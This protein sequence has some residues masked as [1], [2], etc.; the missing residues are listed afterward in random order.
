[1]KTLEFFAFDIAV[2]ARECL[3]FVFSIPLATMQAFWFSVRMTI[4]GGN[5]GLGTIGLHIP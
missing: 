2:N 1:M 3:A 5:D 4:F